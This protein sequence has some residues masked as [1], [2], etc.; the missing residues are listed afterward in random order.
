MYRCCQFSDGGMITTGYSSDG[1]TSFAVLIKYNSSGGR[2][3]LRTFR[4]GVN[5]TE[6]YSKITSDLS[7]NIYVAGGS[8]NEVS[9]HDILIQNIHLQEI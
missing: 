7:G 3:W 2:E 6:S 5:G 8:Y 4:E 9:N 1:L